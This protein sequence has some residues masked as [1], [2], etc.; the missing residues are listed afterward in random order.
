MTEKK[1]TVVKKAT[2]PSKPTF[3]AMCCAAI[4][5]C[6]DRKGLSRQKV[7]KY[8][9]DNYHVCVVGDKDSSK[10]MK[11]VNRSLVAL[12]KKGSVEQCSGMGA[13]GSFKMVAK[14]KTKKV[15]AKSSPA[16]KTTSTK[17]P[18]KKA[19]A[20]PK[21]ATTKVTQKKKSTTTTT[22]KTP[23]KKP[24]SKVAAKKTSAKKPSAKKAAPKKKTSPKKK[25]A[26]K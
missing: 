10:Q 8:L 11:M 12:V 13:S 2:G 15:A 6:A 20:A 25:T 19:T 7:C 5:N 14:P 3:Q 4:T 9:A 18:T 22:K 23:S 1:T 21:K 16:K 26:K 17:K 24:K